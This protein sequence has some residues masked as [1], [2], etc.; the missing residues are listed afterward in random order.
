M[1]VALVIGE[2]VATQKDPSME[3]VKICVMR[4]LNEKLEPV[5]EPFIATDSTCRRGSGEIVYI[6]E[7][8]DA[9][10]TGPEGRSMP[11]DAAVVGIVDHLALT[12]EVLKKFRVT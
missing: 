12:P 7:G 10:F 1:D 4:R 5:G 9:V 2:V 11:V 6:V 8:G 3:G